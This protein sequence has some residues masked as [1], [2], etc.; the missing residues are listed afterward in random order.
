MSEYSSREAAS[1]GKGLSR[2]DPRRSVSPL[3]SS[4]KKDQQKKSRPE[5]KVG[6]FASQRRGKC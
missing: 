5:T 4:T 3:F 2:S 1:D 6:S